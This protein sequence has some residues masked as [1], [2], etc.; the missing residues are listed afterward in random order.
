MT[1]ISIYR[2]FDSYTELSMKSCSPVSV[3]YMI[4]WNPYLECNASMGHRGYI[5]HQTQLWYSTVN[6]GDVALVR[7]SPLLVHFMFCTWSTEKRQWIEMSTLCSTHAGHIFF[8]KAITARIF[9]GNAILSKFDS[10]SKAINIPQIPFAKGFC[11][12]R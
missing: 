9:V 1:L 4:Y 7:L 11:E 2:S 6:N 8:P 10:T 3:G 12:Q 5:W